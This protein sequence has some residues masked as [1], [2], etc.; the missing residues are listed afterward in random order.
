MAGVWHYSASVVAG[1]DCASSDGWLLVDSISEELPKLPIIPLLRFC[2]GLMLSSLPTYIAADQYNQEKAGMEIQ[3]GVELRSGAARQPIANHKRRVGHDGC[4]RGAH[5][6]F[7]MPYCPPEELAD[8][9][10]PT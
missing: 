8:R 4:G 3:G 1:S 10:P 9:P 5:M 6:Y 2:S 7:R